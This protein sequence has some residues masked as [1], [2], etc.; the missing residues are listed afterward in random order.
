MMRTGQAA[1]Q[2][3]REISEPYSADDYLWLMLGAARLVNWP[4]TLVEMMSGPRTWPGS[5]FD[6][7]SVAALL[8]NRLARKEKTFSN[9]Y[10]RGTLK[11][12]RNI[13]AMLG[14]Q[15]ENHAGM[16]ALLRQPGA[17]L[18]AVY[19]ELSRFKGWGGDGFLSYQLVVDLRFS[20]LRE[21]PD[22]ETWAA[23]GPGTLRGVARMLGRPIEPLPSQPEALDYI[24]KLYA[25]LRTDFT[26]I[27]L[28]VSD[29][30]N[31][32]C[33]TDKYLRVYNNEPGARLRRYTYRGSVS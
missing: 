28:D 10:G 22:R 20:L 14:A 15:F 25:E 32:L 31:I 30:C 4:S 1:C 18:A 5:D 7:D 6:P 26:Y 8:E 24:R 16:L 21:A 11:S 19:A 27:D 3:Y 13:A 23:A 29:V 9:A 33:D 17:T 12:P 2:R